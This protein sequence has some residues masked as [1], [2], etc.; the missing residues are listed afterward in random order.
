[1]PTVPVLRDWSRL[2]VRRSQLLTIH[3]STEN[4][5]SLNFSFGVSRTLCSCTHTPEA[6]GRVKPGTS[7]NPP[8]LLRHFKT[9]A[10]HHAESTTCLLLTCR[11]TLLVGTLLLA[12]RF[13]VQSLCYWNSSKH[14]FHSQ[15]DFKK[16]KLTTFLGE[17]GDKTA[18]TKF[19]WTIS[20]YDSFLNWR[21]MGNV[22]IFAFKVYSCMSSMTPN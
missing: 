13:S 8:A 20:I 21:L 4:N 11:G 14:T 7:T 18:W 15:R 17:K 19:T 16:N 1:M 3:P 9:P 12:S 10:Q 5:P 6:Q 22:K 2:L